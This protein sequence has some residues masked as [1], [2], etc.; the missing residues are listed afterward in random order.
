MCTTYWT[1]FLLLT[2]N[3]SPLYNSEI[4]HYLGLFAKKDTNSIVLSL[5]Y[6]VL[7]T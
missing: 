7:G 2:G 4:E 3:N 6:N 5:F 1:L